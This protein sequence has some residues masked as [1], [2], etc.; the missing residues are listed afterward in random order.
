MNMRASYAHAPKNHAG[1][2]TLSVHA[3]AKN[4]LKELWHL[5]VCGGAH[6]T[7]RDITDHISVSTVR[8][9]IST[10]FTN[11][12]ALLEFKRY[13]NNSYIQNQLK[14]KFETLHK[15]GGFSKISTTLGEYWESRLVTEKALSGS[16]RLQYFR[17]LPETSAQYHTANG[18][19][20][21]GVDW[22]EKTAAFKVT[23]QVFSGVAIGVGYRI[24]DS[25]I[26]HYDVS[27][28]NFYF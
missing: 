16:L 6:R 1:I 25:T 9:F 26:D 10:P 15:T 14:F 8:Q 13:F 19:K 18:R 7:H 28:P 22:A 24:T 27:E 2:A 11:H 5:D 4:Y 17:K 20:L 23:Y 3:C 12:Q 21:L